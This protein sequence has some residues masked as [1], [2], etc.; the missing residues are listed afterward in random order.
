MSCQQLRHF[1]VYEFLVELQKN[2]SEHVHFERVYNDKLMQNPGLQ[3]RIMFLGLI[4]GL[5]EGA[6]EA[7]MD[8]LESFGTGNCV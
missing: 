2:S 4:C 1:T 7:K 3:N 5:I 8:L 6:E